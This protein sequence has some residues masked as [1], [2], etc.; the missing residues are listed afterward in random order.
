MRT[1]IGEAAVTCDLVA[2]RKLALAGEGAFWYGSNLDL[3]PGASWAVGEVQG[4]EPTRWLAGM[5]ALPYGTREAGQRTVFIWPAA[6]AYR[7]WANVP[8]DAREALT[9]WYTDE[10]IQAFADAGVYTGARVHIRDDGNWTV[11]RTG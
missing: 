8:A 3:P 9:D 7:H 6:G 4:A 1:D 10:E 11:F 2:L 5:L